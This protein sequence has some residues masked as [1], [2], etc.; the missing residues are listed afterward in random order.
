MTATVDYAADSDLDRVAEIALLIVDQV[1]VEHPYKVYGQLVDMCATH[2][3]KAAQ[4][5][6]ALAIWFDQNEITTCELV[7]RAEAVAAQ[8]HSRR[9][10]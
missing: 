1:R 6:A 8:H 4:V 10:A 9:S 2:P 3:G 5:I 7:R